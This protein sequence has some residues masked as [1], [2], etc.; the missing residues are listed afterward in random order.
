M[1]ER[2]VKRQRPAGKPGD[3]RVRE[4]AIVDAHVVDQP[5]PAV[6]GGLV[7]AAFAGADIKTDPGTLLA[8]RGVWFPLAMVVGLSWALSWCIMKVVLMEI[9]PLTANVFRLPLA[10]LMLTLAAAAVSW[11][12]ARLLPRT[13]GRGILAKLL[14]R[15]WGCELTPQSILAPAAGAGDNGNIQIFKKHDMS[16][17]YMSSHDGQ[18]S[19][20]KEKSVKIILTRT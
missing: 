3:L 19:R 12:L 14:P 16:A 7:F 20:A 5:V 15:G 18:E 2:P 9:D 6:R 8:R 10:S 11:I 1:S 4:S 13:R 17:A